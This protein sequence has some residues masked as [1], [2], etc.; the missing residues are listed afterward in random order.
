MAPR[1]RVHALV[2]RVV[3]ATGYAMSRNAYV[4]GVKQ[5]SKIRLFFVCNY[6]LD[7]VMSNDCV[8]NLYTALGTVRK[9]RAPHKMNSL[10]GQPIK[11]A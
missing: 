5:R 7:K 10:P 9:G 1:G 11:T 6:K 4:G 2:A 3:F 8:M